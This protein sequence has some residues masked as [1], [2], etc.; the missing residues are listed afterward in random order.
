[1]KALTPG[2]RSPRLPGLPSSLL[3]NFLTFHPQS[4]GAR[5]HRFNRHPQREHLFPG[6]AKIQQARRNTPP[7]RVRFTTDRH[8]ASGCSPPRLSANAV[9]FGYGAVADPDTDLHRAVTRH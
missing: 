5:V 6:F 8:F 9:T 2:W 3:R 1:M 7:K 4:R